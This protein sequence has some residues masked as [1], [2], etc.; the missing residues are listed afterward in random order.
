MYPGQHFWLAWILAVCIV[1]G[2]HKKESGSALTMLSRHS[3]GIYQGNKL[4]HNSSGNA[5]PQL[6]QL[7]EPL[8]TDPGLKS[9]MGMCELI[10]QT[11]P[12][13]TCKR[14]KSHHRC[15]STDVLEN[16]GQFVTFWT[17]LRRLRDCFAAEYFPL[18]PQVLLG[19]SFKVDLRDNWR[20][21]HTYF[22]ERKN[23]TCFIEKQNFN[24]IVLQFGWKVMSSTVN[25][26]LNSVCIRSS[27]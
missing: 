4:M 23:Y 17:A 25:P 1:T 12:L 24:V 21:I 16:I 3:V 26:I 22:I 6:F 9:W 19:H 11:F 14:E 18:S 10:C 7:T 8:W 20:R 27:Q 13:S 5:W 15:N 2:S